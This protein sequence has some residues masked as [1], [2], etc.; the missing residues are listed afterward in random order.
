MTSFLFIVITRY[1]EEEGLAES[2]VQT[3]GEEEVEE[4]DADE[5]D[6]DDKSDKK[7]N[8]SNKGNADVGV[9]KIIND[10]NSTMTLKAGLG[11]RDGNDALPTAYHE[12]PQN[13]TAENKNQVK[14]I[15]HEPN[16]EQ[17]TIGVEPTVGINLKSCAKAAVVSNDH[18][19][20][21]I[22]AP[23]NIHL[24]GISDIT[25][26]PT[27]T[28]VDP[29]SVRLEE[30]GNGMTNNLKSETSLDGY[31]SSDNDSEAGGSSESPN[32]VHKKCR[33][34]VTKPNQNLTADE[35]AASDND[36]SGDVNKKMDSLNGEIVMKGRFNV[37][38]IALNQESSASLT[39]FAEKVD[40]KKEEEEA[41][42]EEN[43]DNLE[44]E[45]L[46]PLVEEL[47]LYKKVQ[48]T[49]EAMGVLHADREMIGQRRFLKLSFILD[50]SKTC[51][52]VLNRLKGL[53]VGSERDSSVS[54]FPSTLYHG[55]QYMGDETDGDSYGSKETIPEKKQVVISDS[56]ESRARHV[57]VKSIKSRLV[58]QQVVNTVTAN[59]LFTFDYL[60]L[61]ILAG[62]IACVG[63][64]EN[65][66]VALV[67]S[68][69][70]SP[71]MGPILA[72]T[73]GQVIKNNEL[74]N[75]GITSEL[76]GL[77]ICLLTG[78]LFG[79]V[80]GGIGLKGAFWG[81]TTEWPTS[82]MVS[83]GMLRALWVGVLI[84]VPSGAGVA[85]SVLG[86]NAGSLVGVAISASLLPPACN[87]GMLWGYALLAA[88][89]PPEVVGGHNALATTILPS[90]AKNTTYL[91]TTTAL[92]PS[93]SLGTCPALVNNEY[94]PTYSCNISSDAA[95]L[96][97][98]SLGL[99]VVNIICIMIM[100]VLV[101]KIKEVAPETAGPSKSFFTEDIEVARNY[102]VVQ[103]GK[104][105]I[106]LGKQ[107]LE[108][109][110][111]IKDTHGG[112]IKVKDGEEIDTETSDTGSDNDE[113]L[114][115]DVAVV[116]LVKTL[117]DV[118]QSQDVRAVL[119]KLP[120][121]P[122]EDITDDLDVDYNEA[123]NKFMRHY[124]DR[125]S[126]YF[127]HGK[128]DQRLLEVYNTIHNVNMSR[129]VSSRTSGLADL[130]VANP[131]FQAPI[132]PR[133]RRIYSHGQEGQSTTPQEPKDSVLY[134]KRRG[135]M[136]AGREVRFHDEERQKL[137]K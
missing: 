106:T 7:S 75:L 97:I 123:V 96:G 38:K 43:D 135:T 49:L 9:E 102:N 64:A 54:V 29:V 107:L 42:N 20:D 40:E 52:R 45:V 93:A 67:A 50:D 127:R 57:F 84:A 89:S 95:I 91:T 71:L 15:K 103:K 85:L 98:V 79:L 110:K 136:D 108:E 58:V 37:S 115:A 111:K 41:K 26:K 19:I 118:Q 100:G 92:P 6:D 30:S 134:Q 124:S 48:N 16:S 130:F 35:Y 73:F 125:S 61:L 2:G 1:G 131:T 63:L 44:D 47:P 76:K 105:G 112:H 32:R 11:K 33:F 119:S 53:G 82:E 114:D 10:D 62:F 31:I 137:F 80:T 113:S 34:K 27:G 22:I 122:A 60:L 21:S 12:T 126:H 18:D 70:I 46:T 66:S 116:D 90:D 5:H 121:F 23:E 39:G 99:T 128:K 132:R 69:L 72:A 88:F 109:Y 101:L 59:A 25:Q 68:M 104:K 3:D 36:T 13:K 78:F 81:S 8:K 14:T 56:R 133:H 94:V 4:G 77:L 117:K 129:S 28:C 17:T 65:S 74:R 87:A 51:E 120:Q 24:Q 83:R 55:Y 86:G